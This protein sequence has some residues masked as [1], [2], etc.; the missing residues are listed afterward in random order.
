MR[1]CELA[2]IMD[3][4]ENQ[5]WSLKR[6]SHS[7]G[8]AS[9]YRGASWPV[10]EISATMKGDHWTYTHT[11]LLVLRAELRV[12]WVRDSLRVPR[13]PRMPRLRVRADLRE[14]RVR[15]ELRGPRLPRLRA[16]LREPRL[17]R[18]PA[19]ADLRLKLRVLA[20]EGVKAE[21]GVRAEGLWVAEGVRAD[22]RPGTGRAITGAMAA[23]ARMQAITKLIWTMM[24]LNK[25]K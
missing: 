25:G 19:W 22:L 15:T 9:W 17:P 14:P 4:A 6:N 10:L 11:S 2:C 18:L 16:E 1:W 23:A 21:E 3:I 24:N 7:L 8:T 12:L 20:E 13:V 5:R